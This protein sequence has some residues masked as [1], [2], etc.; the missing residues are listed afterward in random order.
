MN[1]YTFGC[2][3]TYGMGLP[4]CWNTL[5][6]TFGPVPSKFAW[7]SV[8]AEKLNCKLNNKSY[9]GISNKEIWYKIVETQFNPI[10]D[11]VICMWTNPVRT[12]FITD[13]IVQPEY[14]IGVHMESVFSKAYLSGYHFDYNAYLDSYLQINHAKLYLD[15]IGVKNYHLFYSKTFEYDI[16]WNSVDFIPLYIEDM[17]Q[18]RALDGVHVGPKTHTQFSNLL[19]DKLTN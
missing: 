13:E 17:E 4:D 9:P 18:D 19:I 3:H 15:A 6:N 16:E 12:C 5:T 14:R 10:D 2:S 11:M 1:L 8:L 7:P